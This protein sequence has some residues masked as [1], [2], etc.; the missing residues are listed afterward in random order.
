MT[1]DMA[2][3][4]APT[5]RVIR[6]NDTDRDPAFDMDKNN[7]SAD[8]ENGRRP[9]GRYMHTRDEKDL[10]LREGIVPCWFNM[11][12]LPAAWIAEVIDPLFTISHQRQMALRGALHRV[13]DPSGTFETT[14]SATATAKSEFACVAHKYGV[15]L[16]PV[17]WLQE[18]AD[19][20][21]TE[22]LQ[23]LGQVAL[24]HA[25]LPKGRRGPFSFWGGTVATP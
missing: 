11:R 21:G 13:E 5:F 15:E 8:D 18:L 1:H 4:I 14:P 16:A 3:P 19:R 2:S 20:Y 6:V 22:T 23:E 10:V 24:D 12:R 9:L 25:R 17:E 7:A